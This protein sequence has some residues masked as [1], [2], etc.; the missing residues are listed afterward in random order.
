MLIQTPN[1]HS[2]SED[3]KSR[4][5]HA[6]VVIFLICISCILAVSAAAS[7]HNQFQK[8]PCDIRLVFDADESG[9]PSAAYKLTLQIRNSVGRKI[10]GV[11]VYWLD[12]TSN[13]IG[14]SFAICGVDKNGV[15]PS[16]AGQ[17]QATVQQISVKLLQK[18]GQTTWTEIINQELVK[19]ELVKQCAIFGY[20]YFDH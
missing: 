11:S 4:Q 3:L 1:Y 18:L 20:D 6:I 12:G 2:T 13:I 15:S 8:T 9:V 17:C 19:F 10:T 14:N 5:T 16:E 7:A